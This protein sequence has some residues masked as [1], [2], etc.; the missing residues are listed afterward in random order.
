[1]AK[2][3]CLESRDV[4]FEQPRPSKSK[5][6]L[7]P[8]VKFQSPMITCKEM[9]IRPQARSHRKRQLIISQKKLRNCLK[10]V[11]SLKTKMI[12]T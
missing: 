11:G 7:K 10:K 8:L 4:N 3:T 5:N 9:R 1:M 2:F 12:Q 6:L